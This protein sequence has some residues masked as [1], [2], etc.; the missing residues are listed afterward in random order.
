M[1]STQG[2]DKLKSIF[3]SNLKNYMKKK[4][5]NTAD[6]ARALSYS[7]TTVSD[8]VNGKKYPRMD[9]VQ[10]I[11]DYFGILKSDLTEEHTETPYEIVSDPVYKA[12]QAI[13]DERGLYK[14]FNLSQIQIP[15][16]RM[17]QGGRTYFYNNSLFFF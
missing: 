8:W 10:E 6:L 12:I 16:L 2:S 11:A 5:M 7:F 3:S 9:K 4:D 14:L 17:R 13:M 15:C 1:P